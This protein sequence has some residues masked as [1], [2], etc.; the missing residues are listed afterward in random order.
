MVAVNVVICLFVLF[1]CLFISLFVRSFMCLV[2]SL[3][4]LFVCSLLYG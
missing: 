1:M 2:I 3:F 4:C